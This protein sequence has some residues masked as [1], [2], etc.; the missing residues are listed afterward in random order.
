MEVFEYCIAGGEPFLHPESVEMIEYLAS[1]VTN[2]NISIV[3][4]GMSITPEKASKIKEI[5][6]DKYK[7]EYCIQVSIDSHIDTINR[8][9]R[10]G[11]SLSVVENGLR[12]W[13]NSGLSNIQIGTVATSI[14]SSHYDE[15]IRYYYKNFG[16]KNFH[17][18]HLEFPN[19]RDK[20]FLKSI[21]LNK[22]EFINLM[23]ALR[24]IKKELPDIN[25]VDSYN[26]REKSVE[27]PTIKGKGC[28]AGV[29]HCEILAN[30]DV[31]PC[32]M[33]TKFILG[34]LKKTSFKEIWHGSTVTAIRNQSSL[35]CDKNFPEIFNK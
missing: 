27:M 21:S 33:A 26:P 7:S 35:L 13:T 32:G 3:N 17:L 29:T 10:A 1:K 24:D 15:T 22:N 9:T 20:A 19:H 28:S 18:M 12:I 25:I 34:S 4:H 5:F 30:L 14:N 11:T 6:I 2:R 23:K 8:K 31:I 16:I